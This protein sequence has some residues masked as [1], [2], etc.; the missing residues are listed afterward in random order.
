MTNAPAATPDRREPLP[1]HPHA[2][3]AAVATRFGRA[4][5]QGDMLFARQRRVSWKVKHAQGLAWADLYLPLPVRGTDFVA[6]RDRSG[7]LFGTWTERQIATVNS[8]GCRSLHKR[9]DHP[10]QTGESTELTEG[11]RSDNGRTGQRHGGQQLGDADRL[12]AALCML[13]GLA[14]R[15]GRIWSRSSRC[16]VRRHFETLAP[17]CPPFRRQSQRC[18][19][20]V[21]VFGA[22]DEARS[23]V[24]I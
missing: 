24:S 2:V 4:G 19:S 11:T 23:I 1:A 13:A 15:R 8:G 7:V 18:W 12:G 3:G 6:C 16:V 21:L 22:S 14:T 17:A 10:W 20:F 5:N 9:R